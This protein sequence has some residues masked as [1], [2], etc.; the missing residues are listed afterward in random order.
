MRG[1]TIDRR[2][3]WGDNR[4]LMPRRVTGALLALALAGAAL[5]AAAGAAGPTTRLASKANN[6][7][8]AE[9]GSDASAIS[10]NASA[11]AYVSTADNLPQGDGTTVQ[12]YLRDLESNKTRLVSRNSAGEAGDD[13]SRAPWL[14]GSGGLIAFQSEASNLPQGDGTTDLIY[15]HDREAEKTRLVSVNSDGEAADEDS[16][17]PSLS[18]DGRYAAFDS[19]ASNLPEAGEIATGIYVHDRRSGRTKLVS[20]A[21]DG[22][23]VEASEGQISAEGTHVVFTSNAD[24]LPAGDGSTY[25]IYVRDLDTGQVKLA[26]K[27]PAGDAPDG[28]CQDEAVS[29][30]GSIAVFTC[31]ADNMP[32]GDGTTYRVYARDLDDGTTRLL[33]KDP[34]GEVATNDAYDPFVSANGRV[35]SFYSDSNNLPGPN[36]T[37]DVYTYELGSGKLTV[38]S[39]NSAG[40]AGD[41]DSE[42]YPPSLSRDGSYALFRTN[43]ENMPGSDGF[44]TQLYVRGPLG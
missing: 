27:T 22:T 7:D 35:A 31:S 33:S 3:G 29:G 26:S 36:D 11:A 9:N 37:S 1:V 23:P 32:G 15:V 2:A 28:D 12:V 14:S 20:R 21:Q 19:S 18:A 13:G 17:E 16:R 42:A 10:G 6:G 40:E 8:A 43:S 44:Y 41:D 24:T 25:R 38:V 4:R 39:R 5:V 34:G 30:D